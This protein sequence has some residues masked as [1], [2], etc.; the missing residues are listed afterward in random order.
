MIGILYEACQPDFLEQ[1]RF[2]R[3]SSRRDVGGEKDQSRES[4]PNLAHASGELKRAEAALPGCAFHVVTRPRCS[5]RWCRR[6]RRHV[7]NG[8]SFLGKAKLRAKTAAAAPRRAPRGAPP[9]RRTAAAPPHR[10]PGTCGRAL[11]PLRREGPSACA[12]A[13]VRRCGGGAAAVR[14]RGGARRGAAGRGGRPAAEKLS[15]EPKHRWRL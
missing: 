12:W 14:R 8:L 2:S 15:S 1:A 9:H 11:A 13:A 4:L 10:R 5:R 6:P 7:E 3:R